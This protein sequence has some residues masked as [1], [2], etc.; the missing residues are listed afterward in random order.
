[1]ETVVEQTK[2]G[3]QMSEREGW[4]W[5]DTC[6]ERTYQLIC[7]SGRNSHCYQCE[8]R[9][10][11]KKFQKTQKFVASMMQG[12]L[13]DD[14]PDALDKVAVFLQDACGLSDGAADRVIESNWQRF[15]GEGV[16]TQKPQI[17]ITIGEC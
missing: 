9:E 2:I 16:D 3:E 6:N 12:V 15:C 11:L 1:M 7:G 17:T 14:Y 5:C 13:D 8:E 4:K 10:Q